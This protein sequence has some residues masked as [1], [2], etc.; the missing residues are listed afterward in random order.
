M[1]VVVRSCRPVFVDLI[2]IYNISSCEFAVIA[3]TSCKITV[4]LVLKRGNLTYREG[5]AAHSATHFKL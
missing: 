4:V 1:R 2:P 5:F 3:C